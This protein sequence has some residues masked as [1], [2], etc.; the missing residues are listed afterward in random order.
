MQCCT[1]L[2]GPTSYPKFC[3]GEKIPLSELIIEYFREK[4]EWEA[5]WKGWYWSNSIHW[6]LYWDFVEI[7]RTLWSKLAKRTEGAVFIQLVPSWKQCSS[8]VLYTKPPPD[9][10]NQISSR[11]FGSKL[12]MD[13]IRF[14]SPKKFQAS[15]MLKLTACV[16]KKK[17][18]CDA[19]FTLL[20]SRGHVENPDSWHLTCWQEFDD[21]I[22][23][24]ACIFFFNNWRVNSE[25]FVT[26]QQTQQQRKMLWK[27]AES[28][29]VRL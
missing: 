11:L 6:N 7:F 28:G 15:R 24:H 18:N 20:E 25:C 17:K 19:A 2:W 14:A 29:W 22:R 9:A 16:E 26:S 1:R 3:Y 27:N 10:W 23:W 21:L 13:Q 4:F 12:Q 8:T 5:S